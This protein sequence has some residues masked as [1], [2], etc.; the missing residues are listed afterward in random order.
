MRSQKCDKEMRDVPIFKQRGGGEIGGLYATWPFSSITVSTGS[1][2]V[3]V[4]KRV[5]FTLEE[6]EMIEPF[7]W[8]PILG[9]GVLIHHKKPGC[10]DHVLFFSFNRSRLLKALT[11][12]GFKIGT[13]PSPWGKP[14]KLG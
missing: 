12:A 2:T 1:L 13:P 8:F 6:V 11:A 14:R 7:R 4:M 5:T 9:E 10:P 3:S